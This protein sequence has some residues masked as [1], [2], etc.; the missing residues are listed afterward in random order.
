MEGAEQPFIVWTGHK[1]LSYLRSAKRLHSR[2]ARWS[3]FLGRFNF[4]L[5]YRTG[6]Q[7]TKP[8][9]LSRQSSPEKSSTEPES[10]LPPSYV[11]AAATWEI[12]TRVQEAQHSHADPGDGPPGCLSVPVSVRSDVLQWGHSSKH[13][14]HPGFHRTLAFVKQQF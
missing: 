13:T 7:N 8:D 2:Q 3:L 12:E 4:T 9:A 1:N 14:C 11:V 10:I 6:S 5:N